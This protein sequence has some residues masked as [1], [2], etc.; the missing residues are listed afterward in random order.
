[1]NPLFFT[2][3]SEFRKWLE[4]NHKKEKELWVGYYKKETGKS[5]IT[6]PQSVE[7]ALCFGW[8]D[9]IRK[10]VD[11]RSY[12]IRFTPRNP[13]SI[14]SKK[15]INTIREMIRQGRMMPAGMEAFENLDEKKLQIYSS[16]QRIVQLKREYEVIFQK[17]KKAWNFFQSQV[18]SYQKL[19]IHW[20]MSAKQEETRL[21]RLGILID[22]STE[23][24][25]IGLLRRN[26][27]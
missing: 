18:P 13:K 8:I 6:W 21:K 16:E 15:N 20:V 24:K 23:G 3:Q 5:S 10:S 22:D 25:K 7:E 2:T 17:N 14:W 4:K 9:G 27:N 1:M 19:V 12:T 26:N 11:D